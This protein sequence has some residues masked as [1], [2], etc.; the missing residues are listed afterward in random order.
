MNITATYQREADNDNVQAAHYEN[1]IDYCTGTAVGTCAGGSSQAA[2]GTP[3]HTGESVR[4][5]TGMVLVSCICI[6]AFV[7]TT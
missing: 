3:D 4:C 5:T 7:A 1:M 2:T 6:I